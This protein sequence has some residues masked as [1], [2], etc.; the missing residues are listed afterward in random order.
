MRSTSASS[1]VLPLRSDRHLRAQQVLRR[2]QLLANHG[3]VRV[4]FGRDLIFG[5]RFVQP[6][7]W[8]QDAGRA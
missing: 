8:R 7:A 6:A 5:D 1:S 2:L 3:V 4:Q